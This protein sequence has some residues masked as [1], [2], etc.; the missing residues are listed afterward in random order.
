[1]GV[2]LS[3]LDNN[4]IG[5]TLSINIYIWQYRAKM[6]MLLDIKQLIIT[7]NDYWTHKYNYLLIDR[8]R[9]YISYEVSKVHDWWKSNMEVPSS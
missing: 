2:L 5:K 3:I 9:W 4:A 6:I 8:I 1:M 7:C